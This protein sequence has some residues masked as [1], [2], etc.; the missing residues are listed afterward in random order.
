MFKSGSLLL[1]VFT[2]GTKNSTQNNFLKILALS[3]Y[4][5]SKTFHL[6]IP[7]TFHIDHMERFFFPIPTCNLK[8]VGQCDDKK[9]KKKKNGNNGIFL[10]MEPMVVSVLT[11]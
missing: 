7:Q 9:R 2:R 11:G 3:I 1:T 5:C 4:N 10:Q 6:E 8:M